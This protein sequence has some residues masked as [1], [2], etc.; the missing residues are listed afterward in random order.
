MKIFLSAVLLIFIM[1]VIVSC[2]K[3]KNDTL[4]GSSHNSGRNCLGCHSDF[5]I[6]GSV[7]NKSFTGPYTGARIKITTQSNGSGSILATLNSDKSGN[8]YTGN[9]ISFGSGV[10]VSAEGTTGTVKYMNTALTDGA[11]NSCHGYSTSKM[12]T[13]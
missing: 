6:A 7:Y 8:F 3:K 2:S 11:C 10:Y 9:S 4:T 1:L 12:W 13:E 5:K